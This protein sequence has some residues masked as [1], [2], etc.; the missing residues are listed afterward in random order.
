MVPNINPGD[1]W[2]AIDARQG[3]YTLGLPANV[4]DGSAFQQTFIA[5]SRHESQ[6]YRFSR[7]FLVLV[8][9]VNGA[10]VSSIRGKR[11]SRSGKPYEGNRSEVP[12]DVDGY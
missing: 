10:L 3:M 5:M 4:P 8:R 7:T 12:F 6:P 11:V 2:L 9:S 1:E